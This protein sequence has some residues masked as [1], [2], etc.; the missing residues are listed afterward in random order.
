MSG[1]GTS[2]L[3]RHAYK[4]CDLLKCSRLI[5]EK[6]EGRKQLKEAVQSHPFVDMLLRNTDGMDP[7]L[8]NEEIDQKEWLCS[9]PGVAE[10]A[11]E[12]IDQ[13]VDAVLD[14]IERERRSVAGHGAGG[15]RKRTEVDSALAKVLRGLVVA[16]HARVIELR[17][18]HDSEGGVG[19]PPDDAA[20]PF[21]RVAKAI[22]NHIAGILDRDDTFVAFEGDYI[23][24]LLNYLLP[25]PAYA[26]RLT[27]KIFK[28][29]MKTFTSKLQ[30]FA[31][32]RGRVTES[33]A[34]DCARAL[35]A[36]LRYYQRD[37][38]SGEKPACVEV[39]EALATVFENMHDEGRT[40]MATVGALNELIA[41]D[42]VNM[43]S[44][45]LTLHE[46]SIASFVSAGLASSTKLAGLKEALVLHSR[47]ML[48]LGAGSNLRSMAILFSLL[49]KELSAPMKVLGSDQRHAHGLP[50]PRRHVGALLLAADVCLILVRAPAEAQSAAEPTQD[51]REHDAVGT[52]GTLR[53]TRGHSR[54]VRM[55]RA[56]PAERLADALMSGRGLWPML[57]AVI[58]RRHGQ[59]LPPRCRSMWLAAAVTALPEVITTAAGNSASAAGAS[60]GGSGAQGD[61]EDS[62]VHATWLTR[63]VAALAVSWL[64]D[65]SSTTSMVDGAQVGLAIAKFGVRAESWPADAALLPA[66]WCRARDCLVRWLPSLGDS[67]LAHEVC[68]ALAAIGRR[69]LVPGELLPVDAWRAPAMAA[70][71]L[72][73]SSSSSAGAG[74]LK[75]GTA[76]PAAPAIELISAIAS[77]PVQS[78]W[79]SASF[80]TKRSTLRTSLAACLC[81]VIRHATPSSAGSDQSQSQAEVGGRVSFSHTTLTR[82]GVT[83]AVDTLAALCFNASNATADCFG[84]PEEVSESRNSLFDST[85]LT[86]DRYHDSEG[87]LTEDIIPWLER[88]HDKLA[89][90]TVV[91]P[92]RLDALMGLDVAG[93]QAQAR[94]MVSSS[95]G[96]ALSCR[97]LSREA[98]SLIS[99]ALRQSAGDLETSTAFPAR[100]RI[101]TPHSVG[102]VG[103]MAGILT[104]R[105]RSAQPAGERAGRQ[106][107]N[108]LAL[109][110]AAGVLRGG[111]QNAAAAAGTSAPRSSWGDDGDVANAADLAASVVTAAVRHAANLT[112]DVDALKD[113][114]TRLASVA[115]IARG[116]RDALRGA[117]KAAIPGGGDTSTRGLSAGA[118]VDLA[119]ALLIAFDTCI[120]VWRRAREDD[121]DDQSR[122]RAVRNASS[123]VF[124][125]D[126]DGGD[127]LAPTRPGNSST[128]GCLAAASPEAAAEATSLIVME[129]LA[130]LRGPAPEHVSDAV[131]KALTGDS[132]DLPPRRVRELATG[133]AS[134]LGMICST[135]NAHDAMFEEID[136]QMTMHLSQGCGDVM[137]FGAAAPIVQCFTRSLRSLEGSD[138]VTENESTAL[139]E[140]ANAVRDALRGFDASQRT[141]RARCALAGLA[142]QLARLDAGEF[143][144]MAQALLPSMCKDDDWRVRACAGAAIATIFAVA[145]LSTHGKL[146]NACTQSLSLASPA[147]VSTAGRPPTEDARAGVAVEHAETAALTLAS[148]AVTSPVAESQCVIA[149]CVHAAGSQH[150]RSLVFACLGIVAEVLGYSS[151]VSLASRHKA[152]LLG[153]WVA[154]RYSLPDLKYLQVLFDVMPDED[155]EGMDA[156]AE[157]DHDLD[158]VLSRL[159][160]PLVA[161]LV[162]H[163]RRTELDW[164]A[165]RLGVQPKMLVR[166]SFGQ[167]MAWTLTMMVNFRGAGRESQAANVLS[168]KCVSGLN[169]EE[170]AEWIGQPRLLL[171][172]VDETLNLVRDEPCGGPED[173]T[174]AQSGAM[175]ATVASGAATG[176]EDS[177][178]ASSV[179]WPNCVGATATAAMNTLASFMG[180]KGALAMH[181]VPDGRVKQHLV[182]V[183]YIEDSAQGSQRHRADALA[184]LNV[185]VALLG[186][187]ATAPLVVRHATAIALRMSKSPGLAERALMLVRTLIA[188]STRL[189]AWQGETNSPD[190]ELAF[191]VVADVMPSLVATTS[192][193]ID[194]GY[195]PGGPQTSTT[196]ASL[197][198]VQEIFIDSA[199]ASVS[200]VAA[201]MEPLPDVPELANACLWQRT[202]AGE[203]PLATAV[204]A[205]SRRAP[206]MSLRG[207]ER[208]CT[209]L[210]ARMR[211]GGEGGGGAVMAAARELAG[212]A[213]SLGDDGL[214]NVAASVLSRAALEPPKTGVAAVDPCALVTP[215]RHP[216]QHA[217]KGAESSKWP[218]WR[219]AMGAHVLKALCDLSICPVHKNA[220]M[221][222]RALR[223]ALMFIKRDTDPAVRDRYN[224][225]FS[226]L[227]DA[228]AGGQRERFV[229]PLTHLHAAYLKPLFKQANPSPKRLQYAKLDA[230]QLWSSDESAGGFDRWV[231]QL[232]PALISY[233]D[234][235]MLLQECFQLASNVPSFARDL[236]PHAALAAALT[237]RPIEDGHLIAE[238]VADGIVTHT[239]PAGGRA[240]A[241]ILSMLETLR[242]AHRQDMRVARSRQSLE[243]T[244]RAWLCPC[245]APVDNVSVAYAALRANKP[246]T[247]LLWAEMAYEEQ[248]NGPVTAA[249]GR[250][251]ARKAPRPSGGWDALKG[252]AKVE[253]P[254]PDGSLAR[255]VQALLDCAAAVGETD[256]V[257]AAARGAGA[258]ARV[259][260][261]CASGNWLGALQASDSM[262]SGGD[263]GGMPIR[264]RLELVESA[265]AALRALGCEHVRAN[266][267]GATASHLGGSCA[268]RLDPMQ[269][270]VAWRL[271]QWQ[272]IQDDASMAGDRGVQRR[273]GSATTDGSFDGLMLRALSSTSAGD[274]TGAQKALRSMRCGE[275]RQM[276]SIGTERDLVSSGILGRLLIVDQVEAAGALRA[277]RVSCADGGSDTQDMDLDW[278]AASG[279]SAGDGAENAWVERWCAIRARLSQAGGGGFEHT[280]VLFAAERAT[281]L[282]LPADEQASQIARCDLEM[283]RRARKAGWRGA[284]AAA[285]ERMS[286][287]AAQHVAGRA[288][289]EHAKLLHADG[290]S[291]EAIACLQHVTNGTLEG[292]DAMSSDDGASLK[293]YAMYLQGKWLASRMSDSARNV[294]EH[295]L[296]PAAEAM[297]AEAM[298]ALAEGDVSDD[299]RAAGHKAKLACR[300]NFHLA[301]L[302]SRAYRN[303]AERETTGEGRAVIEARQMRRRALDSA[304]QRLSERGAKME[305]A[306]KVMLNRKIR[307]LENTVKLDAEEETT[308]ISVK[309]DL[310]H[311]A[312]AGYARAMKLGDAYDLS[313][314][315][316]LLRIWF[317]HSDDKHVMREACEAAQ[318]L[319]SHKWLCVVYQVAA[320][321][322]ET[323]AHNEEFQKAIC[324]LLVRLASDHPHHALPHIIALKN[325][326]RL[327]ADKKCA[328]EASGTGLHGVGKRAAAEAVLTTVKDSK[329]YASKVAHATDRLVDVYLD[330]AFKTT[331]THHHPNG[332]RVK[333]H[334]PLP[335][336]AR[337][338]RGL[339]EAAI[340]TALPP[341]RSDAC[342]D[343]HDALG[344][345]P[346]FN[347]FVNPHLPPDNPG[348][349]NAPIL[350]KVSG[351]DG[352]A[353]RQLVKSGSDDLRQDAVMEQ[354]FELVN[355]LLARSPEAARRRLRVGTYP[356]VPF[357]PAA[358]CVGFV[359][360]AIE[361]GDWLYK[362][363]GGGAHGRY[364]PQDWGFATCRRA[365]VDARGGG[366]GGGA[367]VQRLVDEYGRV[368]ENFRPVLRHFFTEHFDTPSE[369]LER[370][371]TYTRSAAASSVV[372]YVMGLGD[373]HASNILISTSTAEVT[374]I[375]LGVA[376]EQGRMLRI[377]ETVPFRLTRDMVDG[378][379]VHGVEGAFRACAGV[380]MGVMR[381]SKEALLTIVEVFI[382]DPLYTWAINDIARDQRQ[383][384]MDDEGTDETGTVADVAEEGPSRNSEAERA[385]GRVR[386]KLD[387]IEGGEFYAPDGQV[388]KLINEARDPRNLAV[389]FAGWAPFL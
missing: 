12:H 274:S 28:S 110:C 273:V 160:G 323:T 246:V 372:G 223:H 58:A 255:P 376:F 90:G 15:P 168:F 238:A 97:N 206:A 356:V 348:G 157:A 195:T 124:D 300:A 129:A 380:A 131:V 13:E 275:A 84:P 352:V 180:G 243:G 247:A 363:A 122:G 38:S 177:G 291:G 21:T 99:D 81:L 174:L 326:D 203:T 341:P 270:E 10:I 169:K 3:S 109:C 250:R 29:L 35:Q 37:L 226:L 257:I 252:L 241:A 71:N 353:Y 200:S 171:W 194:E 381:A 41:R 259:A 187:R 316:S 371:L 304:K 338:V 118:A 27:P 132:Q 379:G 212:V 310:L 20:P 334:G 16:V 115:A 357:S 100:D 8:S 22:L 292:G 350:L 77:S 340:C 54:S 47:M 75:R 96:S 135:S 286:G 46:S 83:R 18:S 361:L 95:V 39:A 299:V 239:L 260:R 359:S 389:L 287:S 378:M 339:G 294:L 234:G 218:V 50:L 289:I 112:K 349:I 373:R 382:H 149:L 355:Q 53:S 79:S 133:V 296:R 164:L 290:E 185:V 64:D 295:Y 236:L 232:T 332:Q 278:A 249:P 279:Q 165:S 288:Q 1:S 253:L 301:A 198:L 207:R 262:L 365:M 105:A 331:Q 24:L 383:R 327:T 141:W 140:R 60:S 302:A 94:Y 267:V 229:A 337:A 5:R 276:V 123:A 143:L 314:A 312:A 256:S 258:D 244:P 51:D 17:R 213:V 93:V 166:G 92:E 148:L 209:M 49:E 101:A 176:T 134:R 31:T 224:L 221:A 324:A 74:D 61:C 66:L 33:Q 328:K 351:T 25:T 144:P 271:G 315:F 346:R 11:C 178:G 40:A 208:A 7:Q 65:E 362:S 139:L 103:A 321:L 333:T 70:F 342:Y 385:L 170:A 102:S 217:P 219:V 152:A 235:E 128:S 303:A 245:W 313:A 264:R 104:Q 111:C 4:V 23:Q 108:V 159:Q 329:T 42:G 307:N 59:S 320:R 87:V 161:A 205:L 196:Q 146:A 172:M 32:G 318:T 130:E 285:L 298:A 309:R 248:R 182:Q 184:A 72:E 311:A 36:L 69:A 369:W 113:A 73:P 183:Q 222:E 186:E 193:L 117:G 368:C 202:V 173:A 30:L 62:A 150:T 68:R 317:N 63:F 364:R 189:G 215:V 137:D 240:A 6:T 336:S 377:P 76:K 366:G 358:G 125:D 230:R 387:G 48:A 197:K 142:A 388:A 192:T 293:A 89:E 121:A 283:A 374:H 114:P 237:P 126:L 98:A 305:Q 116:V 167:V 138:G 52:L 335:D 216:G 136:A 190:K 67:E 330:I 281:L 228:A 107:Q 345:F 78:Q 91:A 347:G 322:D 325:G 384:D 199:P 156:E 43:S 120:E 45:L 284:A 154:K 145:P 26:S 263:R 211:G 55:R 360:G 34:H 254:K 163:E 282:L 266:L 158:E 210:Q 306:T 14:K 85:A 191:D 277:I 268:T 127:A 57:A 227:S 354:L 19:A 179:A 153:R 344:S 269:C 204:R 86:E 319:P 147:C 261:A 9:C 280:E 188:K 181:I 233:A 231:C 308:E 119:Q 175:A 220:A 242:Q 251:S 375:D 367:L 151:V 201:E 88:H 297:A 225:V 386:S 162:C 370:R 272:S 56:P 155:D 343:S 2:S 82:A 44:K 265:S 106:V 80:D 214:V